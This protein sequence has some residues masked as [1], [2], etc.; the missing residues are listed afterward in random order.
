MRKG[1][2]VDECILYAITEYDGNVTDSKYRVT[3]DKSDSNTINIYYELDETSPEYIAM[4]DSMDPEVRIQAS[5][6][7][8]Y[9]DQIEA[10]HREILIGTP[11]WISVD[12]SEINS[13][14]TSI[15][16]KTVEAAS[17]D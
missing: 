10:A 5:V 3:V 11:S 7:K 14:I 6:L 2:A 9:S 8:N 4:R 13:N 15:Q 16:R 1:S 17:A 12:I